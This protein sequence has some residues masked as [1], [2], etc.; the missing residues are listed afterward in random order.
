MSEKQNNQD[1]SPEETVFESVLKHLR[2][3]RSSKN[4]EI[5]LEAARLEIRFSQERKATSSEQSEK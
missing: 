5:G 4:P 1:K 3:L 2:M